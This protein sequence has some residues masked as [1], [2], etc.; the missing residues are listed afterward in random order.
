MNHSYYRPE[1]DGLRCIAVLAVIIFHAEFS[2][3]GDVLLSGGYIDV[4]VFFVISGYLITSIISREIAGTGYDVG[5]FYERRVRRIIPPLLTVVLVSMPFAWFYLLPSAL[6]DYS[7][8]ILATLG[9]GSNFWFW[10]EDSY[11]AEAS[12]LKPFLHTWS[13]SVEEQFYVAYPLLLILLTKYFS[14]Y[15]MAIL[16]VLLLVSLQ[17]AQ[18]TSATSPDAAF[19]LLPARGWELL[20]GAL[21][22]RLELGNERPTK[23]GVV[24]KLMPALGLLLVAA[25]IYLFDKETQHPS[26]TIMPVLGTGI[27]IWFCRDKGSVSYLLSSRPMVSIG[28]KLVSIFGIFLFLQSLESP[29]IR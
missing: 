6:Q 25:G 3:N 22:A 24:A 13:L 19:Y 26:L 16:V 2:W 28:L 14:K 23:V 20:V 29:S 18:S 27:L 11:V 15:V 10:L 5:R 12:L 1:I 4:D 7:G 17:I 9:F 21:I 8:S